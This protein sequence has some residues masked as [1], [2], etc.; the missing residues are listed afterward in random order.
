MPPR[1]YQLNLKLFGKWATNLVESVTAASFATL[2]QGRRRID[3]DQINKKGN[4]KASV[5]A[6]LLLF[7]T[8]TEEVAW[9]G[10]DP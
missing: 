10:F 5:R 1:C 8:N 9:E 2:F 7:F 4:L 6:M 3:G